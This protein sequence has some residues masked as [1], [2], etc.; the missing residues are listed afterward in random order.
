MISLGVPNAIAAAGG[1]YASGYAQCGGRCAGEGALYSFG[2]AVLHNALTIA[3]VGA[4]GTVP[5][6]EMYK[7]DRLTFMQSQNNTYL[8]THSFHGVDD[9]LWNFIALI[10]N[11]SSHTWH[12][13]DSQYVPEG[14]YYRHVQSNVPYP[15]GAEAYNHK[16]G[17]IFTSRT[18]F[19][20][21]N[22]NCTT[23]FGYMHPASYYS[24]YN[25]PGQGA[26]WWGW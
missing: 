13:Q 6:D 25:Y 5:V 21:F 22:N 15:A 7:P 14:S 16:V 11:G 12:T 23:R 2:G 9:I 3:G 10:G 17:N 4:D 8:T 18:G 26:Y 1:G 20:L 19:N 24:N